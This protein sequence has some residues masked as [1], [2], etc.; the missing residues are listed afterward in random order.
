MNLKTDTTWCELGPIFPWEEDNY[1]F[2]MGFDPHDPATNRTGRTVHDWYPRQSMNQLHGVIDR[3]N[4]AID[5]S[6][7]DFS[8]KQIEEHARK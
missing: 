1:D 8:C 5:L 2:W 6:T 7:K 3:A 4:G